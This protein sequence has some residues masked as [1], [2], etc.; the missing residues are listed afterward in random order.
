MGHESKN[1]ENDRGREE[2]GEGI[3]TANKNGISKKWK[4]YTCKKV[5]IT[6]YIFNVI[7]FVERKPL[8]SEEFYS[9]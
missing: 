4:K 1:G 6:K 3:D 9:M 5:L 2:R 7:D 8:N